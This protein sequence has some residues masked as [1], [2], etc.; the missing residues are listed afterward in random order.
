MERLEVKARLQ[1]DGTLWLP[2]P[3]ELAP[4][5]ALI[6]SIMLKNF[7]SEGKM[8]VLIAKDGEILYRK[9]SP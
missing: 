2:V 1:S 5:A 8:R 6:W 4:E 9:E 3:S 7:V